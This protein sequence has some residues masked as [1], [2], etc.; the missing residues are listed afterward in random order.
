MKRSFNSSSSSPNKKRLKNVNS[1]VNAARKIVKYT[2]KKFPTPT[3]YMGGGMN[4]KVFKTNDPNSL[5][6]ITMGSIPSEFRALSILRNTGM[7]PNFKNTNWAIIPVKRRHW[8]KYSY[9][10]ESHVANLFPNLKNNK[11]TVYVMTRIQNEPDKNIKMMSLKNYDKKY[12]NLFQKYVVALYEQIIKKLKNKG[13]HHG[14]LHL[15]NIFVG[16]NSNG[17]IKTFRVIDFGRSNVYPVGMSVNEMFKRTGKTK[18]FVNN[19]MNVYKNKKGKYFLKNEN[20]IK[21]KFNTRVI[22]KRW[23]V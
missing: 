17:H 7:A 19:G 1:R 11:A 12:P 16:I 5:I 20:F 9:I 4:G 15:G 18:S 8:G 10:P 6:K 14:N 3:E 23:T 22:N 21:P 13:V 2:G